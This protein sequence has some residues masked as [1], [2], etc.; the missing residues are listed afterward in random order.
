MGL[1]SF[2]FEAWDVEARAGCDS[3]E[4]KTR[5]GTHHLQ[6]EE[7][8]CMLLKWNDDILGG[9][10]FKKWETFDHPQ[11]GK[12]EIGGWK[13]K[14]TLQNPPS[15]LLE[16]EVDNDMMFAIEC[17]KLLPLINIS[18]VSVSRQGNNIY[19]IS[20]FIENTG[21]FPTNITEQAKILNRVS[22]VKVE[23]DIISGAESITPIKMDLAILMVHARERLKVHGEENIDRIL[24]K[25]AI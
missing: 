24:L 2:V 25:R 22:S 11:L 5:T 14:F 8:E 4:R 6:F 7:K 9:D 3:F 13:W 16:S 23:L 15:K 12:I 1:F 17:A 20:V 19:K 18:S 10:G 21:F